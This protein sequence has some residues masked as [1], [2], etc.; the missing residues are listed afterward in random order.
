MV[1]WAL[2]AMADR[3]MD[4]VFVCLILMATV[5]R[6]MNTIFVSQENGLIS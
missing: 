6:H 3:H 4:T 2:T 5:D 1:Q